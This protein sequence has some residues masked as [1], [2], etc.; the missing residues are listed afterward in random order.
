MAADKIDSLVV[1]RHTASSAVDHHRLNGFTGYLV[2]AEKTPL[3]RLVRRAGSCNKYIILIA[4]HIVPPDVSVGIHISPGCILGLITN[5]RIFILN[6]N[7]HQSAV[8]LK[9]EINIA[10]GITDRA[11]GGTAV[12][13]GVD[14]ERFHGVCIEALNTAVDR[15]KNHTIAVCRRH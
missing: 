5:G 1:I 15:H 13:I 6:G 11:V 14:P 10:I 8:A 12:G 2:N 4:P 9:S 7:A 3:I